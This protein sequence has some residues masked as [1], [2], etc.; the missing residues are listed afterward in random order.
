M[1]DGPNLR[2][3]DG[4][5]FATGGPLRIVR[6]SDG[7]YVAGGGLLVPVDSAAEGREVIAEH[8][9][10]ASPTVDP[11]ALTADPEAVDTLAALALLDALDSLAGG[12]VAADTAAPGADDSD[13]AAEAVEHLADA[14]ADSLA[15]LLA[16]VGAIAKAY[17]W[18]PDHPA[19][20]RLARFRDRLAGIGLDP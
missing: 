20:D 1:I 5:A 17:G 7:L 6:R 19:A 14:L 11:D 3:R 16:R 13:E 9:R 2:F 12:L 10:H 15:D 4:E 8:A 18:P